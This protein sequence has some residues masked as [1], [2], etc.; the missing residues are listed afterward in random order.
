MKLLIKTS[1]F[2]SVVGHPYGVVNGKITLPILGNLLLVAKNGKLTATG[3]NLDMWS[4]S[5][6]PCDVEQEGGVTLNARKL[7]GIGQTAP[8]DTIS[9]EVDD[10]LNAT[11]CSGQSKA[12]IPGLLASDFPPIM[13]GDGEKKEWEIPADALR[14]NLSRI[15][16]SQCM[17]ST[18]YVLSGVRLEAA[19]GVANWVATNGRVISHV[20][21][22]LAGPD[23]AVTLPSDFVHQALRLSD[24]GG[25]AKLTVCENC[26]RLELGDSLIVSKLIEGGYPKWKDITSHKKEGSALVDR[27]AFLSALA[28]VAGVGTTPAGDCWPYL[29]FSKNNL[30]IMA[31]GGERHASNTEM[32]V[33]TKD[34]LRIKFDRKYLEMALR[35]LPDDSVRFEWSDNMSPL[36][37]TAGNYTG[38]VMP[39]RTE[40]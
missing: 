20:T 7:V 3:S 17:D 23:V 33:E 18:R 11:I 9:L 4:T 13:K 14:L 32:P 21:G 24:E 39:L 28:Q 2:R 5:S 8:A 25:A 36:T 40:Y 10:Q 19:K 12:A 34:S 15:A 22:D 30:S 6:I 35:N 16:P 37:I 26:V 38:V 1:D 27:K 29:T 31:D